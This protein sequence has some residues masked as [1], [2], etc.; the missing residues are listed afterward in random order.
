MEKVMKSGWQKVK[1]E[2]RN[3]CDGPLAY[4]YDEYYILLLTHMIL[5]LNGAAGIFLEGFVRWSEYC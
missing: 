4:R 3:L 1:W 2:E 5:N